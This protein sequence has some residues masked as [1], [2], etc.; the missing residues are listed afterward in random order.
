MERFQKSFFCIVIISFVFYVSSAQTIRFEDAEY[1]YSKIIFANH[2]AD[3]IYK[4]KEVTTDMNGFTVI[5]NETLKT[6][7]YYLIL[8]DSISIEVLYDEDYPGKISITKPK[9]SKNYSITGVQPTE[10]Y[11][12][13]ITTLK[14]E[15]YQSV[16][17]SEKVLDETIQKDSSSFLT[18]YLKAQKRIKVPP[19][20]PPTDIANKDSAIWN[21]RLLYYQQHYLDNLDLADERLINTPIYTDR[22]NEYLNKISKQEPKA[23]QNAIAKIVEQTNSNTIAQKFLVNYLLNKYG[24]NKGNPVSEFIYVNMIKDYYLTSGYKWLDNKQ[25][26]Y[27]TEEYTRLYPSSI[28]QPAPNI[29][30]NSPKGDKIELDNTTHRYTI[31]YFFNYDCPVCEHYIP[32][33]KWIATVYDYLDVSIFTVCLGESQ[34]KWK[35][36]ISKNDLADWINVYDLESQGEV[37][38]NYNLRYTPTIFVLDKEKKIISKNLNIK[39]LEEL[40]LELALNRNKKP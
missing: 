32:K 39:Q 15:G 31:L 9:N 17:D 14:K 18:T 33:L 8:Q 27:L 6:G 28:Y 16:L 11:N 4:L 19:Y 22:I 40:F 2:Y 20:T 30:G 35:R 34:E 5:F 3:G 21:Y 10:L 36:Y 37:S 7:I 23:I 1:A 29:S 38:V 13:C 25:T 12:N 24:K 26:K